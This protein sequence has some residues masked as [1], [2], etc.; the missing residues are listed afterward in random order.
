VSPVNDAPVAG[1]DLAVVLRQGSGDLVIIVSGGS[2]ALDVLANDTDIENDS[3]YIA[4]VGTPDQGGSLVDLGGSLVVYTPTATFT[5]TETFTYTVSDGDLSDTATVSMTVIEGEGGG[6]DGD[7]VVLPGTGISDTITITVEIP[8]DVV[9]GGQHFALVYG[10]SARPDDLPQ[11]YKLAGLAFTLDAYV[12]G[13][14]T[15]PFTFTP[16]LTL[17]IAYSEADVA[18]IGQG[19]ERLVLTYWDGDE[20]NDEGI[21]VVSHDRDLNQMVVTISHLT[22]FALFGRDTFDVYLPL[23]LRQFRPLG[24]SRP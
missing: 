20:W 14:W 4:G 8:P 18:D 5:G 13:A 23:V 15:H 10:E 3:L 1:D 19:D 16:P 7:S 17:T 21:T 22:E 12:D 6:S 2:G 11:G 24:S 9:G